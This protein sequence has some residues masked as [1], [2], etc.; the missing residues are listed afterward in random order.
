MDNSLHAIWASGQ[1]LA[2]TRA[3]YEHMLVQLQAEHCYRPLNYR[4]QADLMWDELADWL[5]TD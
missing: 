4:Q 2:T 1:D 3:G 5:A